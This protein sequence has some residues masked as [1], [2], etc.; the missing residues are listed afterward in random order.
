MGIYR[1]SG[2]PL[3]NRISWDIL[4]ARIFGLARYVSSFKGKVFGDPTDEL[5]A[6]NSFICRSHLFLRHHWAV[7]KYGVS[8]TTVTERNR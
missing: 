2:R 6:G 1:A 8:G 3:L 4:F 5:S 7:G